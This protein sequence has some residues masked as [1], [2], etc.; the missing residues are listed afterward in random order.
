[1]KINDA[2]LKTHEDGTIAESVENFEPMKKLLDN[3]GCGFCLAKWN[4]VTTHLGS[5]ITHSCHHVGAHKIPLVELET[6]P[7]ALHNTLEKK[8]RRKE[9]LSGK[10]PTECDYCWRIEDSG[11][12]SDRVQKSLTD[13]ATI[14]H[15]NIIAMTGDENVNPRYMEVSF[16]NVCNFKCAY[17][18]PPF[19]SKWAEEVRS[20]GPYKLHMTHYNGIKEHEVQIPTREH[21]PYIEAFWEWFPDAVKDMKVFRITGGEPLLSKD[22]WRV[23]DYLIENPQ[24]ELRF[25][26]NTNSCPPDDLW[27]KFVGKLKQLEEVQAVKEV[28]VFTSAEAVGK[29]LAYSR[30]G[31][32]WNVLTKNVR[33]LLDNTYS[34]R[35]SFMSAVNLYSVPTFKSYIYYIL[36]LMKRYNTKYKRVKVDFAYV[37]H[38][39]FLDIK[40]VPRELLD[41]YIR[42]AIGVMKNNKGEFLFSDWE[43][44]RIARIYKDCVLRYE[45][46][47]PRDMKDI[48]LNRFRFWQFTEQYDQR[49]QSDFKTIFPELVDFLQECK[50]RDV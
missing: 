29:Q 12:Y 48:S 49:R 47:E 7:S 13:W 11:E 33:L 6:N 41:K 2:N 16:S 24:P 25:S 15:D 50:T 27:E 1:M 19:S 10:R 42:P 39:Y 38:P 20:E 30:H 44:Q 43:V 21:N 23:I 46:N 36:D 22:T 18:G 14:D 32:D 4:Q 26:I 28:V 9:M 45:K 17:C 34:V 5:G 37:R 40:I 31:L 8:E 3:T 35:L